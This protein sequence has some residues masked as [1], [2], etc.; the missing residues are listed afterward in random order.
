[1]EQMGTEQGLRKDLVKDGTTILLFDGVCNFCDNL[2]LFVHKWNKNQEIR[3]AS[4]QSD[5]GQNILSN[6]GL[7][8]Q[9][10]KT[11]IFIENGK[12][13]THS[14]GALKLLKH[15]GF[16]KI[17]YVFIF[18]PTPIRNWAYNF[19]AKNRYKWFGKKES[20]SLPTPELRNRFLDL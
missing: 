3:F 7:S 20:C 10:L 9:E 5:F 12:I 11:L 16:W 6:V 18:V 17:F 19:I 1:M 13:H 8:T 2:V 15:L 4:L 14:T